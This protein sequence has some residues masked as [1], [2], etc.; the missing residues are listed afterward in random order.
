[1]VVKLAD[2]LEGPDTGDLVMPGW[3][4]LFRMQSEMFPAEA[5]E[6]HELDVLHHAR[7]SAFTVDEGVHPW[8]LRVL[9][10]RRKHR[11]NGSVSHGPCECKA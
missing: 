3:G 2:A 8:M 4:L 10:N 11:P 6:A 9:P 5:G 7:H 1:M